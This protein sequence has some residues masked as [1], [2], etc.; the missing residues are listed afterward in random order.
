MNELNVTITDG[1]AEVQLNR[2]NRKNALSENLFELLSK[3]GEDLKRDPGLR[4]VVLSGAGGD[5]CAGLDLS[6][7]QS[8]ATRLDEIRE[9]LVTP[10]AGEVANWFQKPC[11]I[12][13]ELKIPV[14]AAIEGVCIGGGMQLALAADFRI[15]HPD[16]R[17][18]IMETKWGLIPDMGISQNLP[19]LLPADRAKLLM[20]TA[21]MFSA[22]DALSDGLVTEIS[23]VPLAR[24]HALA[25]EISGRSPD[26]VRGVKELVAKTW[27]LPDGEGLSVEA[28]IQ[29]PIIGG[30]NQIEAVMANMQK[31]PPKFSS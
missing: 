29:A 27:N 10:P 5:F 17:L 13:Q 24:A 30:P 3:T 31:R 25:Q 20:M 8:F 12:W 14:I 28:K 15:C 18:S 2:P 1:I 16:A 7:M 26:A 22:H 19:K 23:D 4:A 9:R 6:V 21:K 11:F